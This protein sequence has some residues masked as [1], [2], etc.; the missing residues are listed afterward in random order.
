MLGSPNIGMIDKEVMTDRYHNTYIVIYYDKI[1]VY[2][3]VYAYITVCILYECQE[4][5]I[6]RRYRYILYKE[7]YVI[8]V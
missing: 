8:H 3:Y 2:I 5:I 4:K 6:N 1:L 7:R